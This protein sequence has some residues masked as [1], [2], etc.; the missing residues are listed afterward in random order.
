MWIEVACSNIVSGD[1]KDVNG[2]ILARLSAVADRPYDH[3]V[4]ARR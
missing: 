3:G 4:S 2:N 1:N